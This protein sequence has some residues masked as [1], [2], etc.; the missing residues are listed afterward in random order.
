MKAA[1]L[2]D[3]GQMKVQDVPEPQCGPGD[4]VVKVKVCTICGTDLKIY[5]YG[6]RKI[7]LPAV[8][9]H[10]IAGVVSEVGES[11]EGFS[12][13]DRVSLSPSG[14]GCGEC[15][16]CRA[17]QEWLCTNYRGLAGKGGF[18]ESVL[19]PEQIVSNGNLHHIPDHLSFELAALTEPLACILNTHEHLKIEKGTSVAIIGAGPIGIMHAQVCRSVGADP[20]FIS[21]I[22]D[23]R[24]G[25]VPGDLGARLI[26]G[27]RE[28]AVEA[29]IG[30]T[31]GIGADVVIV[32]APVPVAQQ[33]SLELVRGGGVVSFFAGLPV[34]TT[35]VPLDTN[36]I[37]YRQIFV[38]GTSNAGVEHS[39]KAL[40]MLAE[41]A[42]DG[43]HVITHTYPLADTVEAFEA[44]GRQIGLKVAITAGES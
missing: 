32:A 37:H 17:D 4:V 7:K 40:K 33:Q 2:A 23:E 3:V 1:M 19:I 24:L 13:G 29:V 20:L 28:D 22:S 39:R 35:E 26:N 18:A 6:H 36:K 34:G 44:A 10:E 25:L 11:V 9:G 27:S 30:G 12:V 38:F 16:Y 14:R 31:K 41:G 15:Y 8:L 21:D 43:N 5:Q 42:I